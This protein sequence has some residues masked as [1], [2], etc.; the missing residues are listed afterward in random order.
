MCRR[1]I[2]SKVY[3]RLKELVHDMFSFKA[4]QGLFWRMIFLYS[5]CESF[6][7]GEYLWIFS[8][9]G[10]MGPTSFNLRILLL[11]TLFLPPKHE[12]NAPESYWSLW[13]LFLRA[14]EWLL[15]GYLIQSLCRID[16]PG[17]NRKITG[18]GTVPSHGTIPC[19]KG[20]NVT[21]PLPSP[22]PV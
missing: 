8:R 14:F 5:F 3:W 4:I 15:W 22:C 12:L 16:S 11:Y 18:H 20:S 1:G 2:L 17:W 19:P 13:C 6:Q 9:L 7:G 21:Q 10:I